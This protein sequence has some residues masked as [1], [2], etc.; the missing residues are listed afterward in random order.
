LR[1]P[2]LRSVKSSGVCYK[3]VAV[4]CG[5]FASGFGRWRSGRGTFAVNPG[6][7]S[8]MSADPRRAQSRKVREVGN[9]A[10]GCDSTHEVKERGRVCACVYRGGAW[11]LSRPVQLRVVVGWRTVSRPFVV[12]Y[13]KSRRGGGVEG[14]EESVGDFTGRCMQWRAC[15]G[16][17]GTLHT[18]KGVRG[19]GAGVS[20]LVQLEKWGAFETPNWPTRCPHCA[21]ATSSLVTKIRSRSSR[22][23]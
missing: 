4:G 11:G 21:C 23:F 20:F 1:S 22:S 19:G 14:A 16:A 9:P 2:I 6:V 8:L 5:L 15:G 13:H 10:E 7:L 3:S 12:F 18:E 17:V